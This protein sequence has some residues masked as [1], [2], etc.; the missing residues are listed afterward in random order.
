MKQHIFA[1]AIVLISPHLFAADDA[2]FGVITEV[3]LESFKA[4]N[5]KELISCAD[6]G[7]FSSIRLQSEITGRYDHDED[8]TD[9][10]QVECKLKNNLRA[11]FAK[12]GNQM[13][14]WSLSKTQIDKSVTKVMGDL[15]KKLGSKIKITAEGINDDMGVEY[16]FKAPFRNGEIR[17]NAIAPYQ[18]ISA[19]LLSMKSNSVDFVIP[20]TLKEIQ[21]IENQKRNQESNKSKNKLNSGDTGI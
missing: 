16:K 20:A 18:K 7:K 6:Y 8:S 11:L 12:T 17:G 10:R 21:S 19:D 14:L 1:L 13:K 3:S 2:F 5:S 4:I 9:V 15:E